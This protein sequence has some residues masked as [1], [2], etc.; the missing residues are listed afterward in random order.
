MGREHPLTEEGSTIF[1]LGEERKKERGGRLISLEPTTRD[2]ERRSVFR[3]PDSGSH[4]P[5]EAQR[6]ASS[7]YVLTVSVA[8]MSPPD[9]GAV[10]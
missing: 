4:D 5:A 2:P 9:N 8:R 7:V 3:G 6:T 10:S 1:S